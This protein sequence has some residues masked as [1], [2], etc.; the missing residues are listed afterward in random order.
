MADK[1]RFFASIIACNSVF[2]EG[3]VKEVVL[4]FSDGFSSI[5]AHHENRIMSIEGG[6]FSITLVDGTKLLGVMASGVGT[7][8]NNRLSVLTSSAEK[9]EDIDANRAREA[10]ERAEE[11]LRQK[12]SQVEYE[13]KGNSFKSYEQIENQFKWSLYLKF[14]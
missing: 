2:Y 13:H 6:P 14:I 4:P 12:Q 8:I 1:K 10:K 11:R 3:Y 9:P 7:M 5:Q